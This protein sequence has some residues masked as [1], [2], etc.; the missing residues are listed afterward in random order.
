MRERRVDATEAYRLATV[1]ETFQAEKWG[2]DE[3]AQAR[4]TNHASELAAAERFLRLL[5]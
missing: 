1:D 5:A 3:E 2:R 4:L